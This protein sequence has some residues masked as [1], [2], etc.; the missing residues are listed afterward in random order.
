MQS[1]AETN[2]L[3]VGGKYRPM[4]RMSPADRWT[5]IRRDFDTASQAISAAQMI[6]EAQTRPIQVHEEDLNPLGSYDDWRHEKDAHLVAE[7]ERVFGAV[8]P[9]TIYPGRG[10]PP[11]KVEHKRRRA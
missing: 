4:Y 11:V 1:T 10:R 7:R 9:S 8:G 2:A 6:V 3:P 5:S